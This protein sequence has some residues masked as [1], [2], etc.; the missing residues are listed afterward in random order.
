MRKQPEHY[1]GAQI[2]DYVIK[3]INEIAKLRYEP[4]IYDND[5]SCVNNLDEL[6]NLDG[7]VL[8]EK[9]I[10]LGEDWFIIYND[11]KYGIL[12][13]DWV[14]VDDLKDSLIRT[15]EMLSAIKNILLLSEGKRIYA[16]M[17]H[18]TSYQFYLR[19]LKHGYFEEFC[20]DCDVYN[21]IPDDIDVIINKLIKKYITIEEYFADENRE[22]Y[23]ECEKYILHDVGFKLTKKFINRYKKVSQDK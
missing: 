12:I 20:N 13:Q 15:S 11:L 17:R 3:R 2:N 18:D 7:T 4:I 9:N 23:K 21:H 10:I 19:Y 1:W 5:F 14:A 22:D 8:E 6:C 16:W